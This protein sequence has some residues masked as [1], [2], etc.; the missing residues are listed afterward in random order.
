[1]IRWEERFE[2]GYHF[3]SLTSIPCDSLAPNPG[4]ISTLQCSIKAHMLKAVA[5]G[6]KVPYIYC[7]AKHTKPRL[8]MGYVQRVRGMLSKQTTIDYDGEVS[9]NFEFWKYW[10][11]Y[12]G[13]RN[14]C[15]TSCSRS[16]SSCFPS[17]IL[18]CVSLR[19]LSSPGS[20]IVSACVVGWR[21]S[22][23]GV[24]K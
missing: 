1:M 7:L 23:E 13:F 10:G 16:S 15:S 3:G 6:P 14:V 20:F 2:G 22:C 21:W 5:M 9:T 8:L 19:G 11:T 12:L 17:L 24:H 4:G 18:F